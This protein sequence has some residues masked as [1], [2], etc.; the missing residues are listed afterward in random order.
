MRAK[1]LATPYTVRKLPVAAGCV[2]LD[3]AS[4]Q[5]HT[6]SPRIARGL[7]CDAYGGYSSVG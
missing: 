1:K 5:R 4:G 3:P 6:P 7:L 2:V